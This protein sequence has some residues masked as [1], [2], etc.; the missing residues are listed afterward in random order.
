[1]TLKGLRIGFRTYFPNRQGVDSDDYRDTPLS[2]LSR[3]GFLRFRDYSVSFDEVTDEKVSGEVLIFVDNRVAHS[4]KYTI[5]L[6][7]R[8]FSSNSIGICYDTQAYVYIKAIPSNDLKERIDAIEYAENHPPVSDEDFDFMQKSLMNMELPRLPFDLKLFYLE[9]SSYFAYNGRELWGAK[10]GMLLK[11]N[12]Q[13]YDYYEVSAK[14]L[15]IGRVDDDI[16]I[17][18]DDV[19]KYQV[20]DINGLDVMEEY[21]TFE[22]FA[23]GELFR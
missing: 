16:Y 22:E 12:E 4:E 9:V 8:V 1:M 6:E 11:M 23:I 19:R 21:D 10:D 2:D 7:N 17:Y 14:I 20:I 18:D 15:F 13:W 5:T 3:F